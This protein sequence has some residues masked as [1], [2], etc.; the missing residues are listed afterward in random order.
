MIDVCLLGTGGAMPL[1]ERDLSALLF[2]VNGSL[3][4]VDC[5]EGTQVSMRKVGWGFRALDAIF[6][7]HVHGDHVSGLPGLLLTLGNSARTEPVDI[8]GPPGTRRVV[9]SLR[10]IAPYLPYRVR[11]HEILAPNIV[12]VGDIK[13]DTLPLEHSIPCLGYRF[14]LDRARPFLAERA[15]A[16]DVPVS[17]WKELQQGRSVRVGARVTDPDDVLGPTRRGLSFAYITDTNPIEPIV[18]FARQVDLL[19]CE[20]NYADNSDRPKARERGHMLFDEA[21]ELALRAGAQRLWLTHFSAA[22]KDPVAHQP[23]ARSIYSG[24]EVGTD[25]MATTLRFHDD[26]P[27]RR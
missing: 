24:A 13:I 20:A 8:Y 3:Y 7:T 15:S 17:R 18:D 5:G 22:I 10:S 14:D 2:R 1:P 9:R 25:R 16:L 4:L 19:V 12:R 23:L 27:A 21:A 11:V 26:A 6:I